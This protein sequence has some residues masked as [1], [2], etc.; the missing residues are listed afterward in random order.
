MTI[1]NTTMGLAAAAALT[2][3]FVAPATADA[4]HGSGAPVEISS[5][6]FE[7]LPGGSAM[8]YDIDGR[9]VMIRLPHRTLVAVHVRGLDP[10]TTYPAHVHN[11]PCSNTPPGGGHY[12]HTVGGP[13]DPVNEIWPTVTTN[14]HGRGH[15]LAAHDH[16][17]RPDAQSIIIHYP[18]DT[19]VRLACVDLT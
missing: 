15:G 1:R 19:S 10:D 17:A 12:Q 9:A 5:G 11:A 14:R 16:R 3:S 4:H 6:E 2:F 18:P 13:V 7:T 8:G